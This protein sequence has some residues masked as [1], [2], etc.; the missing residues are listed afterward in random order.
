MVLKIECYN[1]KKSTRLNI[2]ICVWCIGLFLYYYVQLSWH[3]W[4]YNA[5]FTFLGYVQSNWN[6]PSHLLFVLLCISELTI[7]K[8]SVLYIHP[9]FYAQSKYVALFSCK[10]YSCVCIR[11]TV[12]CACVWCVEIFDLQGTNWHLSICV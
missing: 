5:L 3:D 7:W 12:W 11:K 9:S 4:H 6:K 1:N 2:S 8:N 10:E